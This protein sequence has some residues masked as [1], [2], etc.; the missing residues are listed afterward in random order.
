MHIYKKIKMRKEK[1]LWTIM[2]SNIGYSAHIICTLYNFI[3][4]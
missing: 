1:G 3:L 2:E 4:I